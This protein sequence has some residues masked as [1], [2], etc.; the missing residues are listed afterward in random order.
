MFSL[1]DTNICELLTPTDQLKFP[2]PETDKV[3]VSPLHIV[4]PFVALAVGK[5][6]TT[7]ITCDV[8]VQF[9]VEYAVTVD[10]VV[11]VGE[12]RILDLLSVA[13]HSYVRPPV[14]DNVM[15]SFLQISA[16][17]PALASGKAFTVMVISSELLHPFISV[18]LTVYLVVLDGL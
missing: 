7:T 10:V 11:S 18:K 1:G 2:E 16:L 8:L 3:A 12:T 5:E 9:S 17:F 13:D 14:A 4:G 15:E 6:F